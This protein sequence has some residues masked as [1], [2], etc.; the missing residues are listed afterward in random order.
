VRSLATLTRLVALT[1]AY[2]VVRA[3]AAAT[4]RPRVALAG[5]LLAIAV[6]AVAGFGGCGPRLRVGTFNVQ[7]LGKRATDMDRLAAIVGDLDVDVLAVEEVQDDSRVDDLARRLSR[8][9]RRYRA[10]VSSCGGKSAM[11][12]AFL[13]DEERVSL[14]EKR[15]Y[16]ELDPGRGGRCRDGERPGFLGVF[17]PRGDTT[18]DHA[19]SLLAVHM[20]RGGDPKDVAE[21][22]KQWQRAYA[23]VEA[24]RKDGARS[25]AILGDTNSTGY[26]DNDHGERDFVDGEARRAG[27]RVATDDLRCSEYWPET[28]DTLAPSLLDHVVATPGLIGLSG[29]HV[30]GYCAAARCKPLDAQHPPADYTSV[31]DH[32]PVTLTVTP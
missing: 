15:E 12:I 3:A 26:L 31:S 21:R 32:C 13:Y 16:P 30:G 11:R 4:A 9:A 2:A 22:K 5:V 19:L 10:V 25:V 14:R 18:D 17:R 29:T 6:C 20:H 23:I 27:M 7:Q 1:L 24:L 28:D 8:G